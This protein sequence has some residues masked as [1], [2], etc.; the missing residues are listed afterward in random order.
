MVLSHRFTHNRPFP[1]PCNVVIALTSF[2]QCDINMTYS[3][4]IEPSGHSFDIEPDETVLDAALRHGHPLP[5]G[6]RNG[7]CGACMGQILE[8]ELDYGSERPA[9]LSAE[10]QARGLAIFCQARAA[11]DLII[12]VK[13]IAAAKDLTIK[14]LPALVQ[15]K[16]QLAEDVIRLYLKLPQNERMQFLAGQYIDILLKDGRKR[17]FSIANTPLDDQLLELHIRHVEG[18]DFTGYIFDQ[19]R[20]KDVLRIDGPHGNFFLREDSTRPKIFVAGG[21]GFA[22][23]KSIL[24]IAFAEQ[25]TQPMS[26][27]WGVRAEKDL[28][29]QTLPQQWA[30][31]HSNFQFVPVLSEAPTQWVGKRGYVHETV[32]AELE[33]KGEDFSAYDVYVCG[34]PVMVKAAFSAFRE[35]GLDE[36]HFYSDAFEFQAPKA[37]G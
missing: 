27:Y 36:A 10:D 33:E 14:T 24:E 30:K 23:V 20:E 13:E 25:L 28:Y 21:T 11:S 35:R 16:E 12:E 7:G 32:I 31:D 8:G 17:S 3:V 26:L 9:A 5:Y 18:G 19:L 2:I 4:H 1:F 29:L 22:P 15:K 34:P 6:C 37:K